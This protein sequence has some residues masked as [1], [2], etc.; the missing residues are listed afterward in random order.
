VLEELAEQLVR[1]VAEEAEHCERLLSLLRH[2]Q[3]HL[4]EGNTS[5]LEGNVLEQ[6]LASRRSREL[7]RRRLGLLDRMSEM[8][9][10]GGERPDITRLIAALS[11]DYGRRL[12]E[13][14]HTMKQS[15]EQLKKTKDQNQRLIE[16][17]L[18]NI[19]ET[20][21][22]LAAAGIPTDYAALSTGVVPARPLAI[23]RRG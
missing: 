13:L 9:A 17:S 4:V 8:P 10:C 20:M 6:E 18:S 23:D 19:G 11:D 7:E 2:Q 22:L 16:R 15:L 14:R 5:E 3:R 12:S 21:R 1:V